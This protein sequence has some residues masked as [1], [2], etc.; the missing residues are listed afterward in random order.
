MS[1]SSFRIDA[2]KGGLFC[3]AEPMEN[4]G[5]LLKIKDKEITLQSLTQKEYN[6]P[7][8]AMREKRKRLR[9]DK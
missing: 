7:G 4:G 9:R 2:D 3:M 1:E 5:I 6:N 8:K